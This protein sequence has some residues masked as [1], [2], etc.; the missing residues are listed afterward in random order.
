MV[1]ND[2]L[3]LTEEMFEG[4]LKELSIKKKDKYS[5]ILNGG[6]D[7]KKAVFALFKKVW[8]SEIKPESWKKT[9]IVQLYKGKGDKRSFTNQR[10]I[11]TKP[12][13]TKVFGHLVMS[14]IKERIMSHMSKFQIGT[15]TGHR[16]QDHWFTLK[17]I[18]ALYISLGLPVIIQLY[19]IQKFFDRESLRDGLDAIYNL[20]IKGKLYRLLYMLNKD[21]KISVKTAVGLSREIETGENIGQGT[22]EG[23]IL[24]AANIDY[25][26]N[27]LFRTS[28]AELSY[29][30][31]Q[32]LP[33]LFQDDICR[34]ATRIDDAQK[35]NDILETIMELK[36][37]DFNLDKSSYIIM[38]T[39]SAMKT[40]EQQ[41]AENP[42]TL[43]NQPMKASTCEKYLGDM[44]SAKGLATVHLKV[45]QVEK[46]KF[47]TA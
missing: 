4:S 5:F 24:S 31:E 42:L 2:N 40:I 18:A 28:T 30:S 1:E 21:T 6:E 34:V 35:G 17:S 3:D 22:T 16:V 9:T 39:K 38:G 27:K 47:C 29:G 19:D 13:I 32:L 20:G 33:L 15:K 36:L 37:L 14:Q 25:S 46:G 10:N 12:E 11:H 45:L 23:A 26:I 8:E 43:C 44:L 41:L 7:L